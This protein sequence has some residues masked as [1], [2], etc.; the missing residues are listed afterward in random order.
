MKILKKIFVLSLLFLLIGT[1]CFGM[2]PDSNDFLEGIDVSNWQGYIDYEKV[3][4]AGIDIIYI[5]SS[6]GKDYIDPYFELNYENAKING[7]KVGVYHYLTARSITEAEQEAE[8]FASVISGK[9]IDCKLAMDFEEFGSLNNEQINDISRA[10]LNRLT[11]LTGK[12]TIVYSDL[13][14]AINR[15]KISEI[16]PLWI[17]YYG[18]SSQL[19]KIKTS[20]KNWQAQQYTDEG[21]VPGIYGYVDRDLF[22][23][24]ILLN[25]N[26]EII[27][28]E[29]EEEKK[30]SDRIEYT[31]EAGDTLWQIANEYNTSIYEIARLNGIDNPNLIYIGEKL[32][33]ITNSNFEITFGAGKAFYTVKKGDTLSS[34]SLRFKKTV[35][36]IVRLNNIQNPNLIYVGQRLRI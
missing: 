18:D 4:N 34:L 17:A 14:N 27:E 15:F 30:K 13:S 1:T 22:T 35:E 6:I 2:A 29:T 19:D 24:E 31:V 23:T 8:F 10:F 20:W 11:E 9:K 33:I 28:V 12:E 7:L 21:R 32:T 3:K 16:S 25:D 36:D 26:S 5:E